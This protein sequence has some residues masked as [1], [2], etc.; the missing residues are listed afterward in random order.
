MTNSSSEKRIAGDTETI[1]VRSAK[2]GGPRWRLVPLHPDFFEQINCWYEKDLALVKKEKL[3]ALGPIVHWNGRPVDR[4][5]KA[6]NRA[7]EKAGITRRLRP[8]D[9]RHAFDTRLLAGHADLKSTS[10]I[11]GHSRP[12]TQHLVSPL[13][14]DVL[15]KSMPE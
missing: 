6:F 3:D 5:K 14:S 8:Y 10:E 12:D 2:K 4:F 15:Y 13:Q 9:F 7:K 11:L 1:L